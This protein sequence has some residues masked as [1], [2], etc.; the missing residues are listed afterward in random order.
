MKDFPLKVL[1]YMV[2]Y[3]VYCHTIC[4]YG[5]CSFMLYLFCMLLP[6]YVCALLL[7]TVP[8]VL[9]PILLLPISYATMLSLCASLCAAMNNLIIAAYV[10]YRLPLFSHH[11]KVT[12]T[13]R[14]HLQ[15][16][17]VCH[18]PGLKPGRVI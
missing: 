17:T 4:N 11:Y 15:V 5:F 6:T 9:Y 8:F 3:F 13:C 14:L 10:L 12:I 2:L 16:A 7:F 1:S 18:V